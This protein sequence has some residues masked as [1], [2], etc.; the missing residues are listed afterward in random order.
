MHNPLFDTV[1][2]ARYVGLSKS[3]M[4][5]ARLYGGGPPYLKLGRLVRY[6]VVDLDEWLNA[7]LRSTTS[8]QPGN[9]SGPKGG[10]LSLVR[11]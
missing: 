9:P 8:D 10:P 11:S 6:R 4:E 5:K 2:A 7:H 1:A 3:T